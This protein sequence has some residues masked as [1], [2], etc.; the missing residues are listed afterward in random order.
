MTRFILLDILSRYI[1]SLV[2]DGGC[3]GNI[4]SNYFCNV[5]FLFLLYSSPSQPPHPKILVKTLKFILHL[6]ISPD[7]KC[8]KHCT[9][10]LVIEDF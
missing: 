5:P 8:Q 4:Y 2:N 1:E 6:T 3:G 10:L 9:R 7:L